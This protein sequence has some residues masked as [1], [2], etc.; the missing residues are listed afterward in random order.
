MTKAVLF[1]LIGWA[2]MSKSRAATGSPPANSGE[3]RTDPP[4]GSTP[5]S[6]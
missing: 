5:A 3:T 2:V 4:P 1:G 6:P